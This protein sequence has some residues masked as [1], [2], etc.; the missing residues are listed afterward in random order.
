MGFSV[1]VGQYERTPIASPKA[2]PFTVPAETDGLLREETTAI[3][4]Q[5]YCPQLYI[6]FSNLRSTRFHRATKK[7]L[8]SATP[9]CH[10]L[11]EMG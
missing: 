1:Y 6:Y 9:I 2:L 5:F 4:A 3:V 10:G 11:L 7:T 8:N